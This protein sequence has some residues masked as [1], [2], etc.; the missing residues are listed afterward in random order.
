STTGTLFLGGSFLDSAGA[1]NHNNGTVTFDGGGSLESDLAAEHFNN[2]NFNNPDGSTTTIFGG[3]AVALGA[4]ALNDG[5]LGVPVEAQAGV[6]V[7]SNFD[8]GTGA[9]SIT[10]AA[11]RTM[12]FATGTSLLNVNVNDTSV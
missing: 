2:L 7:G 11:T 10:G 12:T 8:G 4:L 6:T 5:K 3:P 1:F 9:L